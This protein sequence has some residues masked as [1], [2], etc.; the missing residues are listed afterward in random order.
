MNATENALDPVLQSMVAAGASQRPLQALSPTE[1][2]AVTAQR[3]AQSRLSAEVARVQDH[4]VDTSSGPLRVRLYHPDGVQAPAPCALYY[5]GGGFVVMGLETHDGICRQLCQ[6]SGSVVVSVDYRL[7]PETPFP[8]AADDAYAALQWVADNAEL[9]GIDR[10]SIALAGDSAGGNLAAATALRTR[11]EGG[12]A[13]RAQLLFYPVLDLRIDPPWLSRSAFANG[14]GMT[15]DT[16]AWFADCYLPD[17][18]LR[19][20]P[21]ASPLQATTL[22]RLP[23]A[24]IVTAGFDVLRDE[25][26]AYAEQLRQAGVPVQLTR[27]SDLN[28]GFLHWADRVPSALIALRKGGTWL[29]NA[30]ASEES[31]CFNR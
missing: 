1:A 9:L 18:S 8:G 23:P 14:F 16:L 11:D 27:L 3:F 17:P 26:E 5:H 13:V 10:E 29:K 25:A 21:Y 12:P 2:R 7:A 22:D 6:L 31:P 20:H 15:R 4:T 24:C 28:H 30:F 19:Q